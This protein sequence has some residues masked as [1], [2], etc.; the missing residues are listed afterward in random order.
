MASDVS[1]LDFPQVI[2]SVYDS[3]TKS[4]RTTQGLGSTEF[5][6]ETRA[7]DGDSQLVYASTDGTSASS[8]LVPIRADANGYTVGSIRLNANSSGETSATPASSVVIAPIDSTSV[9][10][11]RLYVNTSSAVTGT[12]IY[13][14]QY[15]PVSAGNIWANVSSITAQASTG[16]VISSELAVEAKRIQVIITS[17]QSSGNTQAYLI[18]N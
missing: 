10:H 2:K 16:C 12:A 13:Q 4:L 18:G 1:K 14:V 3:D 8:S 17:V 15:S 5:A 11:L 7:T 6:I 9:S